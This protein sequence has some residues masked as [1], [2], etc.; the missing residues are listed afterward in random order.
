MKSF[1]TRLPWIAALLFSGLPISHAQ[2]AGDPQRWEGNGH[3]YQFVPGAGISWIDANT[4]AES[5]TFID[6]DGHE[7]EGHLVTILSDDEHNFVATL[8]D[9]TPNRGVWIGGFQS[10]GATAPDEGW[11]WVNADGPIPSPSD[12]PEAGHRQWA[13]GEPNETIPLSNVLYQEDFLALYNGDWYSEGFTAT[14]SLSGYAIAGYVVEYDATFGG[15]GPGGVIDPETCKPGS[16]NGGCYTIPE[17]KL[18]IPVTATV[19]DG[20]TME[21][22][23]YRFEDPRSGAD[24][25]CLEGVAGVDS[26][27]PLDVFAELDPAGDPTLNG[28]LIIPEYLCGSPSFAVV[29]TKVTG[30]TINEGTVR[31]ENETLPDNQFGCQQPIPG[32]ADPQEQDTVVWQAT[33]E[34]GML[35]ESY[36]SHYHATVGRPWEGSVGEFT[37]GCGSSEGETG[38]L[39]FFVIGLHIDFGQAYNNNSA[40]VFDEFV[41]LTRY[42]LLMLRDAVENAESVLDEYDHKKLRKYAQQSYEELI[43]GDYDKSLEKIEKFLKRVDE[44]SYASGGY[45]HHGAHRARGANIEFMLG[46]KI[47]PFAQ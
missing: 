40:G 42:K 2:V 9:S 23:S 34:A 3:Y 35:E 45:N 18:T 27:R 37:T 6:P 30:V 21:F 36:S 4:D 22:R 7:L 32:G 12:P 31:V 29:I 25:R 33:D 28:R 13:G 17:Q 16:E 15:P 19:D 20:A 47:I 41:A 11:A 5:R 39:S 26:R 14:P 43:E 24:G 8:Y 44:A 10:R 38:G 1:K 46:E